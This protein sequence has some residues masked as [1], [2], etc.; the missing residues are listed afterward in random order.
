MG[1]GVCLGAAVGEG[2]LQLSRRSVGAVLAGGGHGGQ[3]R[4]SVLHRQVQM[5]GARSSS[6]AD[7][8]PLRRTRAVQL[9][10]Q[11]QR[12]STQAMAV[13]GADHLDYTVQAQCHAHVSSVPSV[14]VHTV[15]VPTLTLKQIGGWLV[16]CDARLLRHEM[17]Q[18]GRGMCIPLDHV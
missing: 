5:L 11:G 3:A 1:P 14:C 2:A 12:N 17:T 15:L 10:N 6:D 4:A 16:M 8:V 13:S 7:A 9:Q 18:V